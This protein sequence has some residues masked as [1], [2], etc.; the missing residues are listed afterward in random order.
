MRGTEP[1]GVTRPTTRP[2][3]RAVLTVLGVTLAV[4]MAGCGSG[5][6][7]DEDILADVDPGAPVAMLERVRSLVPQEYELTRLPE[8]VVYAGGTVLAQR[9]DG[10]FSRMELTERE[11]QRLTRDLADA[12]LGRFSPTVAAISGADQVVDADATAITVHLDGG[13]HR[14]SA[15]ALGLEMVRYPEPVERVAERL[16]QLAGRAHTEGG[17]WLPER[18]RLFVTRPASPEVPTDPW[19]ESL[20]VPDRAAT[21]SVED[22]AT[23]VVD[24]AP[25]EAAVATFAGRPTRPLEA[26]DGQA[27]VVSWRPVLPHEDAG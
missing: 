7:P 19:P 17:R 25:I 23:V 13:E 14:L 26:P 12:D 11:V 21:A 1:V 27:Y 8:V 24:G 3:T 5:G 18:G 15:Y 10:A 9:D 2:M 6:A 16:H 4:L 20:P 22:P